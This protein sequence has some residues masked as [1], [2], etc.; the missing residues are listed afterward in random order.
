MSREES[1]AEY[2]QKIEEAYRRRTPKSRQTVEEW[3]SRY[4]PG[5]DY[6][7]GS[8]LEPYP[9]VMVRGDG[10]YLHDVDGH[11]YIDFSNNW[12]AL[13][14]GNNPP[15]V[16]AAIREEAQK[17]LAMSAPTESVYQWGQ[18]I[19]ERVASVDRVRF[20]CSGSEAAMFAI[21]GAR[22]YTG[23]D[24]ILKMEGNYHG[25]YDLVE[26]G[27]GWQE[28]PPG[29]P[30]SVEQ[31]VLVTRFNDKDT[32]ERIIRENKDE[33]AAVI[34]EGI[35]G[36]GGL[37]PPKDDYLKFLREVTTE[38]DVLLIVDEVISFRL[39][40]GGAQQIYDVKPDLTVFGKTIG[41][42]LPVGAFGGR[43]DV[44]AV[45]SPKRERPAH[46]TGT[47]VASPIVAA[48]G[49]AG[50]KA[51]TREA[52]DRINSL[53]DSLA[54]GVRRVLADLKIKAQV[55]GYGSL[56]QIHFTPEPVTHAAVSLLA[57]DRDISRL[58]H[59]AML[60]RGIFA[61]KRNMYNISMP[62]TQTEIDKAVTA[63]ADTLSELKPLIKKIA[64][65][66]I[67]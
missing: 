36:A 58:F 61:A 16:V 28:L 48:A 62:M 63:T 32:A 55:T 56:Q 11:R 33:L 25:T 8:W 15:Q 52:L 30:R 18:M 22:A 44:M 29:L 40:T 6:R 10:C 37:I 5:G 19:C 21:R 27:V 54:E 50:L 67:Y 45:F 42:G 26:P 20:C 47:F 7:E 34:V 49:I 9:T 51:M 66:L 14:W 3:A 60:N 2:T 46:H 65:Q 4:T 17:G 23:R 12:T 64:P 41:G 1:L 35:M 13:V 59:L 31:D 24:K 53:G 43:E 57:Q 39:A 38:N